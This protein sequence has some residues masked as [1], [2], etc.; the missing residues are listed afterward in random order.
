M[1]VKSDA[2]SNNNGAEGMSS[3]FEL[4]LCYYHRLLTCISYMLRKQTRVVGDGKQPAAYLFYE[5]SKLVFDTI[6]DAKVLVTYI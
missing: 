5:K 2:A 6:N 1:V 3:Q 4:D